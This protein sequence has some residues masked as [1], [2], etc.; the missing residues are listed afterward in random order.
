MKWILT[1][2]KLPEIKYEGLTPDKCLSDEV[3]VFHNGFISIMRYIDFGRKVDNIIGWEE[4]MGHCHHN[5][6]FNEITHWMPL[7]K[8]P[9][10]E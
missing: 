4:E 2:K 8:K 3:L 9:Q 6:N 10:S 7:P 1:S 5:Y